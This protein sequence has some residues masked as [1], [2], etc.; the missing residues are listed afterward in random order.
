MGQL[1]YGRQMFQE[2]LDRYS[3][4]DQERIGLSAEM[5]SHSLPTLPTSGLGRRRG[6]GGFAG[7]LCRNLDVVRI[8]SSLDRGG[9]PA[10][11]RIGVFLGYDQRFG[12]AA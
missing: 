3:I 1:D 12:A 4:R 6:A 5:L 2:L 8:R 7:S 9:Q 11:F 10:R